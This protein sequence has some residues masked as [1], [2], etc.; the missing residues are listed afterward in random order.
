MN[1]QA[2]ANSFVFRILTFKLFATKILQV[3]FVEL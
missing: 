2:I 3:N 1:R